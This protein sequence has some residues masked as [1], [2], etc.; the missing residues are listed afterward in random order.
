MNSNSLVIKQKQQ[1]NKQYIYMK[2]EFYVPYN[3]H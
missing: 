3:G 1:T 2:I